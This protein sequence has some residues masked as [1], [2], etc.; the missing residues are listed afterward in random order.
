MWRKQ[1]FSRKRIPTGFYK[2]NKLK[3]K[4]IV[5]DLSRYYL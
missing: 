1:K 3:A 5:F 2:K 4:T